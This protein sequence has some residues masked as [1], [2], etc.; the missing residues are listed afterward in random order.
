[1]K[2]GS[3]QL[4][5]CGI[6]HKT[7]SLGEREPLHIGH[8]EIARVSSVFGSLPHVMESVILS[9]CNRVEFY[10]VAGKEHEPFDIVAAFYREFRGQDISLLR[11]L[12]QMRKGTH[13]VDHLFRVAAGVDSMVLGENQ[14]LGQVKDAYSSACAVKSVGKILHRLFHQSF[15]VG[16]QVRS[17][18]EMGKGTCSVSSAAVEMLNSKIGTLEKPSVLF[19]GINQMINL[20]ATNLMKI[21]HS[22]FMFANRTVEKAYVFAE[23]FDA[24]GFG[25]DKLDD[26]LSQADVVISCTSSPEHIIT[27]RMLDDL[28]ESPVKRKRII[29]D[30]AI[31]RDVDYPKNTNP[32]LEVYDLEDIKSFLKG[33]QER[34]I[35]AIP[36]AEEII[37]IRLREFNYWFEHVMNEPIYNGRSSSIESIRQEELA[38]I[39]EK[40]PESIQDE[41]NQATRRIVERVIRKAKQP[42]SGQSK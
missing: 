35:K 11:S 18:T 26:L 29:V 17:D 24:E 34:R 31:P 4:T 7:S 1:M 14:I 32:S 5:L 27:R 20:A 36:Q 37:E 13:A 2:P 30:L 28:A 39:L 38:S 21:D 15:R 9:T 23:K 42:D 19:V 41:L 10:F 8:D 22:R 12:F 33:Q 40:L 6:N 3:W 25:L 16:K